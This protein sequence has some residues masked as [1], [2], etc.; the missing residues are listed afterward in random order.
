[1]TTLE[2]L[3]HRNLR[4]ISSEDTLDK[5]R[6]FLLV[7]GIRTGF[8]VTILVISFIYQIRLGNFLNTE[9]WLPIY[10]VLGCNFLLN[11]IYLFFFDRLEKHAFWNTALF[12][13]DTIAVS[14]LIYFTGTG[15]SLFM[16][17]YLVNL[18]LAGL[19]FKK[20]SA[21]ALTGWTSICFSLLV[22]FSSDVAGQNL[23]FSIAINNLAFIAVT[24]L[25]GRLAGQVSLAG[26]R[27]EEAKSDLLALQ[28]FNDLIVS[29]I[30]SGLL[31]VS[32][33][34]FVQFHNDV[35]I[36][37]LGIN[38]HQMKIAEV[39]PG[40]DWDNWV[41]TI[42]DKNMQRKEIKITQKNENLRI[43]EAVVAP[44]RDE[45]ERPKGWLVRIEDRTELKA[46]EDQFRQ[47]EK[48]A[49]VG[50]LA[51]GI[52]HEIRNPLASISGSIQLLST[53]TITDPA[54]EKKLM[55][56]VSRE[57]DRL[58]NLITEFLEYVRPEQR[59]TTFVDI[60]QIMREVLDMIRF[61]AKLRQDVEQKITFNAHC[62]V[63]GNKDKLKQAFLNFIVNSYQAMEKTSRPVL[64]VTTVDEADKVILLI[65]D[66]GCGIK[67]ENLSRIFEPFH[68]TK[69]QGSGLGLAI[70]HKILEAHGA[71]VLVESE[72]GEGTRFLIEF[73]SERDEFAED[74]KKFKLA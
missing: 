27:L 74:P 8:L 6:P 34:G 43:L 39:M 15:Q 71:R 36:S 40:L 23:Y 41:S 5:G 37:F 66:N 73:P 35:A 11:S 62:K 46:L 63:V 9:M 61:N 59:M 38:P 28:N 12:A 54:E 68:T 20:E 26:I 51:A 69:P 60:N 7:H 44:F 21:W 32:R 19:V 48:L 10:G 42:D 49:A 16:F 14:L 33:T 25:S 47:R 30:A 45:K 50:Q 58:N 3:G 64:E 1:M 4:V 57:I 65:R 31:V 67:K 17:L 55:G 53:E 70:T 24:F 29:N 2:L 18:I 22:L 13:L 72:F 56:I 52:A